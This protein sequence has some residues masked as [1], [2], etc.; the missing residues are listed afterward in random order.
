MTDHLW[1]PWRMPYLKGESPGHDGECIFCHKAHSDDDAAEHVLARGERCFVTLNLYPY[2]NGHL[3]V[4]PYQHVGKLD[5][6]DE[7]TLTELMS[8]TQQAIRVLRAAYNPDGFNIGINQGQAAG[9]GV[10]AHL[11]QHVVPRWTGDTSYMTVIAETRT[12]P[13]WID[14]TYAR[15]HALWDEMFP[16]GTTQNN[17][18]RKS[19]DQS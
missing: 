3:M 1:T 18:K 10:A 4:V 15:L 11:H 7:A 13:E 16:H 6:L 14:E 19:D 9:A 17:Q 8:L 12:I 5:E 2:N